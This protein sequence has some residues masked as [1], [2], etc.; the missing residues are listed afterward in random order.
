MGKNIFT[1]R[2]VAGFLVATIPTAI[3][4]EQSLS[5]NPMTIP[6]YQ[7]RDQLPTGDR[8][9]VSKD[10]A[11]LFSNRCGSCHLAGGMGTNLLTKQRME[12]GEPPA[13]GLLENRTDLTPSYVV[14]IA[15]RGKMAMPSLSRVDV[16]DNEL[17]AIAN[18]LGRI[19]K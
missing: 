17:T 14:A 12:L 16:T 18:Y 13:M 7:M 9:T 8:L 1:A 11:V 5:S 6:T 4:A 10:G 19:A 3:F 2:W 15:R